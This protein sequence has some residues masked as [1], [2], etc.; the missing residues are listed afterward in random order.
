MKKENNAIVVTSI[1][2]GVVLVIALTAL[3]MYGGQSSL[4]KDTV[5]VQGTSTVKVIPD[6]VSV[7]FYIETEGETSSE[8]SDANTKIYNKLVSSLL[9]EG[10]SM[11]EIGTE[12][13]QVYP[14]TYWE[15]QNMVT[16][17]F[18]AT[19]SI[20]VVMSATENNKLTSAV[21]AGIE[22]GAGISFINFELSQELQ[23][24][25]KAEALELASKDAKDKADAVARGFGKNVGRL[26]S[27]SV[28]DYGYYPWVAYSEDSGMGTASAV[29]GKIV[30]TE[31]DISATVSA[32][33]KLI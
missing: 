4:Q 5:T 3:F 23:N 31:Q 29:A 7:H 8:A 21:D 6:I 11:S 20:K 25:N 26:V 22:S 1:I 33:Y 28:N 17:G 9:L 2:A 14:N 24:E 30:P 16:E 13:Y 19:R 32:V 27:V 15:G 18:I 10:F 12:N